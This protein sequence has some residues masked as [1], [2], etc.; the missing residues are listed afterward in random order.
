VKIWSASCASVSAI[1][2]DEAV[3][4]EP[5]G[6]LNASAIL[7]SSFVLSEGWVLASATTV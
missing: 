6:I 1:L 3:A 4:S 5:T 7:S 2:F